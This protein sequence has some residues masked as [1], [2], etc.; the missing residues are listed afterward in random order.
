M[1]E[2]AYNQTTISNAIHTK[3]TGKTVHF[4]KETNSTNLWVK[5][6]AKRRSAGRNSGGNRISDGRE[7]PPGKKLDSA[8]GKLCDDV[9]ASSAGI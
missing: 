5:A 3:W 9:P 7:G 8:G 4:A 2:T 6:L 1:M